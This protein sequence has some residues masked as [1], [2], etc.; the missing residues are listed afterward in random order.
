GAYGVLRVTADVAA[1]QIP[2]YI[3][4]DPAKKTK[5]PL[6]KRKDDSHIADFWK[7]D[8]GVDNLPDTDDEENDPEGDKHPGDGLTLNEE[9]RG[10][11]ENLKHVRANPKKKDLFIAITI[12]NW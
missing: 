6:P 9:Y 8:K 4:N 3:K 12:N 7:E 11:S 10:F 1:L 5:I 2:G